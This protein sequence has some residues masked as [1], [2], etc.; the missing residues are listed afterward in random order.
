MSA[1]FER[2]PVDSSSISSIGYLNNDGIL[3]IEFRNG[4]IYRL[5]L[6]PATVWADLLQ[7]ESKGAFFNRFIRDRYPHAL[8]PPDTPDHLMEDLR[9]S[10]EAFKSR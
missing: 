5:F 3:E 8:I 4:S 2:V 6:V 9:L 1:D 10:L 7:S